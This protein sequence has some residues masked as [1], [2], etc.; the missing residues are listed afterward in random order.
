MGRRLPLY[1]LIT[2]LVAACGTVGRGTPSASAPGSAATPAEPL[3]FT[4]ERVAGGAFVGAE[5]TRLDVALWFW[6]PW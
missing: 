1:L 6:A 2:L 4:A 5:L 3:A